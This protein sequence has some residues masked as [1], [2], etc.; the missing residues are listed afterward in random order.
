M[1]T[2]FT[3]IYTLFSISVLAQISDAKIDSILV[4]LPS[5][6]M[7]SVVIYNPIS[8]EYVYLKNGN[9]SLTPASNL[10]LITSAV[11]LKYF[12][13]DFNF[14]TKFYLNDAKIQDTLYSGDLFIKGFGN[15]LFKISDIDSVINALKQ[16]GIRQ[17]NG[18]IITDDSFFD[19]NYNREEW[20][21]DEN[22]NVNVP[23]VSAIVLDRNMIVLRLRTKGD[24]GSLLTYEKYPDIKF[25]E[26]NMNARVRQK[27]SYP[28][29]ETEFTDS[30]I[31][32]D[33][34]GGL[35]KRKYS[36]TYSVYAENPSLFFSMVV[37]D[38]LEKAGIKVIGQPLSATLFRNENVIASIDENIGEFLDRMNKDSDNFI[39]ESIFKSVGAAY[40]G[41]QGNS[42]YATQ[43]LIK[44][45]E[46]INAIED[47]IAI[48]DGSG[49]SKFNKLSGITLV[50]VLENMYADNENFETFYNSLS[51]LGE[52]GTLK[53]RMKNTKIRTNFRGKTGTLN[54]VTALSGYLT[55]EKGNDLI[56]SIMMEYKEKG[57]SFHKKAQDDLITYIF[58]NY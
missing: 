24:A 10:K 35:I 15:A 5:S 44:Y 23:P 54:G 3:L 41:L 1:K 39:A 49:I 55:T 12:G 53:G 52:D 56:I 6:S 29:F 47:S 57:S 22:S 42:F 30:L 33:I 32:I 43:A 48:L 46:N 28:K 50:K 11:A 17:I 7:V 4:E 36:K 26:V 58:L 21:V 19:N 34:S 31:K 51:V 27:R 40:S 37:L 9:E 8:Q 20:I 38:L 2:I 18:N 45:L 16:L 14:S 13:S 25:I